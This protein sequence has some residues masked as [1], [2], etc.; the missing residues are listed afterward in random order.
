MIYEEK[1][2]AKLDCI[3][4][5][6]FYISVGML[7]PFCIKKRSIFYDHHVL[8]YSFNKKKI[9]LFIFSP[10]TMHD[11]DSLCSGKD[12]SNMK[13]V[14]WKITYK[15]WVEYHHCLLCNWFVKK[16]MKQFPLPR[17]LL[18]CPL[19]FSS[20]V[21]LL[22]MGKLFQFIF[23]LQIICLLGLITMNLNFN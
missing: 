19:W 5:I 3:L 16:I 7:R 18:I 1:S 13:W 2:S 12:L 4:W 11:F 6:L 15:Y 17:N 21:F 9:V 23:P 14:S 8:F 20:L 22:L 10:Y